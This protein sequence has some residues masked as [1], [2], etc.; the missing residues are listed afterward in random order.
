MVSK[1]PRDDDNDDDDGDDDDGDGDD[2]G[3]ALMLIKIVK[4]WGDL[5]ENDDVVEEKIPPKGGQPGRE[6]ILQGVLTWRYQGILPRH[7]PARSRHIFTVSPPVQWSRRKK[8]E[9]HRQISSLSLLLSEA[10][11]TSS[12]SFFFFFLVFLPDPPSHLA[13]ASP[14]GADS[15]AMS[16]AMSAAMSA[17]TGSAGP[18]AGGSPAAAAALLGG[19]PE[20]ERSSISRRGTGSRWS[21]LLSGSASI[22]VFNHK[23]H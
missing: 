11:D 5:T 2:N 21:S 9:I 14:G 18:A 19:W 15:A 16:T 12:S 3:L 13:A 8:D 23:E 20:T 10:P 17:A 1:M 7:A 4:R 22:P 6:G